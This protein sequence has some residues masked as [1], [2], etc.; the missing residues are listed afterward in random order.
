MNPV[1]LSTLS[2]LERV[3]LLL[4]KLDNVRFALP[5][6]LRALSGAGTS[7]VEDTVL[8][9]RKTVANTSKSLDELDEGA[10][11]CSGM[12]DAAEL[13]FAISPPD[14]GP[15]LRYTG[16]TSRHGKAQWRPLRRLRE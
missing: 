10:Q 8:E 12:R 6:V 9:Y 16:P 1:L 14:G 4:L 15:G 5:A 3:D 13:S 7:S 11:G 2:D